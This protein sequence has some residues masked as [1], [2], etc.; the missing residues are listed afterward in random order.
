MSADPRDLHI[1]LTGQHLEQTADLCDRIASCAISA[2]EAFFRASHPLALHHVGEVRIALLA[3]IP[4]AK[5]LSDLA[6]AP[7]PDKEGAA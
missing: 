4:L 7:Q 6:M 2:R 1:P 3:L 5:R